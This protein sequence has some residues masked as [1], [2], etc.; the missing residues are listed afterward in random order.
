MTVGLADSVR[1]L[2]NVSPPPPAPTAEVAQNPSPAPPTA[3]SPSAQGNYISAPNAG[4]QSNNSSP[5]PSAAAPGWSN[6]D[7]FSD[8]DKYVAEGP[9][10]PVSEYELGTRYQNGDGVEKNYALAAKFF[11]RAAEENYAP[12]QSQL[13]VC[14]CYGLGVKQ[15]YA[16][17][18]KW[19]R[20]AAEKNDLLSQYMLGGCYYYGNGVTKSY[21]EAVKWYR[22]S[23]DQNFPPA[24]SEL[25][26]C[27]YDGQGVEK[28]Y[29]EAVKWYRKAAGQNWADAQF[30]LAV[31]YQDR[32][33]ALKDYAEAVK[34]YRKAAEQNHGRAQF[35]LGLCYYKGDGVLKDYVE[36]YKWWLLAAAK[37]AERARKLLPLLENVM[38][39]EQVAEGQKLARDFKP[40][41]VPPAGGNISSTAVLRSRP[42]SSGSGFF[43]TDDGFLVTN[44]HVIKDAVQ[45]RLITNAGLNEARVVKVDSAND[46]ALLKAEGKF[47]ALSVVASRAV[48]LGSTVATV[49]FPNIGLQGFAP[50][51]AKGDIAAL[52]GPEDDARFFQISAPVQPGNSGGALVDERGNVVGVVSAKLSARATLFTSGSLPENVNYAVKSSFLLSFLESV[53]DVTAK[54]K[55]QNTREM[56]F[57]EVV[58]QAKDAAVLVLVY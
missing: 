23:A 40:R 54:L 28:N 18:V 49:G 12:A 10:S 32:Q 29:V 11:R 9:Y 3:P 42:E 7:P 26:N 20:K 36:A 27:Y 30:G 38:S 19:F 13:G 47:P 55:E 52:T 57:D 5:S 48:R 4:L 14:Y 39:R 17:A 51:L 50:K 24:Q 35:N 44:E 46:L 25:G 21:V 31:C 56:K 33:G 6:K 37:G 2:S 41:E 16:E 43:I 15:S 58:E 34:W 8:P 45:I 53:P 1:A 22:K